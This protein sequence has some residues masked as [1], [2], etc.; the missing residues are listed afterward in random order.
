MADMVVHFRP[1]FHSC[2]SSLNY[3]EFH[4]YS[5]M[6]VFELKYRLIGIRLVI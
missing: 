3:N 1:Q 4:E 5:A 2:M 6:I